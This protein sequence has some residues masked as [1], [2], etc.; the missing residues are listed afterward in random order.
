MRDLVDLLSLYQE[1]PRRFNR[2]VKRATEGKVTSDEVISMAIG[3]IRGHEEDLKSGALRS[4]RTEKDLFSIIKL[5]RHLVGKE[6]YRIWNGGRNGKI[7][8]K[9]V[10]KGIIIKEEAV[11]V[12]TQASYSA[13]ATEPVVRKLNLADLNITWFLTEAECR[14]TIDRM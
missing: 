14:K 13:D 12:E 6:V 8:S 7:C 4:V 10:V 11:Y 5:G 9:V 2:S 1:S 3:Y